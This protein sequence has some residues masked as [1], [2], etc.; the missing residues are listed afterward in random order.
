[1]DR[2]ITPEIVMKNR[3]QTNPCPSWDI[4]IICFRDYKGSQILV[5]KFNALPLGYKV[6]YGI[7]EFEGAPI[8][9]EAEILGKRV[10]IITRCNWG[11]PQAAILVEEL[12]TMGVKHIIGYGAAGSI[13]TNLTQGTQLIVGSA[14]CNDGTSKAYKKEGSYVSGSLELGNKANQAAK[15]LAYQLTD[16][17]AATVDALYRETKELVSQWRKDGA[18]I[19]N[20]ESGAF[21]AASEVCGVNSIWLGF[22]S[23]CL[24]KETWDDWHIN[25]GETAEITASICL[26]TAYSLL[27]DLA[28]IAG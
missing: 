27:E 6:L 8:V 3:F 12:S 23:D 13:K 22:V 10:G 26:K 4:A 28:D 11:A 7:E 2:F 18:D 20:M 1:M 21:Y 17:S 25:L 24:V 16:V 9:F 15:S 14:L 5:K 19:V